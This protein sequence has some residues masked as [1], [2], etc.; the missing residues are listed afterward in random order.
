MS[1]ETNNFEFDL[2]RFEHGEEQ[3]VQAANLSFVEDALANTYLPPTFR[4]KAPTLEGVRNNWAARQRLL[5]ALRGEHFLGNILNIHI[6]PLEEPAESLI[7]SGLFHSRR[8]NLDELGT[9]VVGFIVNASLSSVLAS[10]A[11]TIRRPVWI[12]RS[13]NAQQISATHILWRRYI[14]DNT[15]ANKVEE[16]HADSV[17]RGTKLRTAA[18]SDGRRISAHRTLDDGH[19]KVS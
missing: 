19:H 3:A 18:P 2:V 14:G 8:N 10:D 7:E 6:A 1:S 9:D 15:A 5:D 12:V 13:A 17:R 4:L 16:L 11:G